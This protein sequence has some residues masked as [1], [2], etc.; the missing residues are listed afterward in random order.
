MTSR[1][2]V[3]VPVYRAADKTA[4]CLQSIDLFTPPDVPLLL[5]DDG[6][7]DDA[8]DALL[9]A[10]TIESARPVQVVQRRD[11][12]GFV[13]TS[14]QIFELSGQSDVLLVNSDVI[15]SPG[16]AECLQRIADRYSSCATVTA[17]TN[18]GTLAALPDFQKVVDWRD[19]LA[20][21]YP[22]SAEQ[23]ATLPTAIGHCVYIRRTALDLLGPFDLAFG[24]GYGEEVDFSQRALR[25]GFHHLLACDVFVYHF[26]SESF[27]LKNDVEASRLQ[28]D[29]EVSRRYPTYPRQVREAERMHSSSG[30]ELPRITGLRSWLVH[31]RGLKLGIDY[32]MVGVEGT[33]TAQ[34][35]TETARALAQQEQVQELTLYVDRD[36]PLLIEKPSALL[37]G[38]DVVVRRLAVGEVPIQHE[39][40]AFIRPSQFNHEDELALAFAAAPR[41][42]LHVLD[43]IAYENPC[44]WPDEETWIQYR[45]LQERSVASADSVSALSE[46]VADW[47]VAAGLTAERPVIAHCGI[48]RRLLLGEPVARADNGRVLRLVQYGAAFLHKNREFTVSVAEELA[49]RGWAVELDLAGPDPTWG[50]SREGELARLS[51]A[52]A[53][54]H[55]AA[56]K[57]GEGSLVWTRSSFVSDATLH[58]LVRSATVV[59]Y[60][61]TVEGFGLVPF[62][63]GAWGVPC[64]SSGGGSLREVLPSVAVL[65]SFSVKKWADAVECL[66]REPESRAANVAALRSRREHLEWSSSAAL[67]AATSLSALADPRAAYARMRSQQSPLL[68]Q[69]GG[70]PSQV[71]LD[72]LR[73][74]EAE[75]LQIY[76][77]RR[78]SAM[79]RIMLWAGR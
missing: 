73:Q 43:G 4:L 64:L 6:S 9:A 35:V 15:V 16:W 34:L 7:C 21:R 10:V 66:A 77:S 39:C 11:N 51:V 33:G 30:L 69:V 70:G 29:A 23:V 1:Y 74:C 78:W 3:A 68:L 40:D 46:S 41:W 56:N 22:S 57:G 13:R 20:G 25:A 26:G 54:V 5:V 8:V 27:A 76:R 50:S 37:L 49:L 75:L 53:A 2:V 36:N 45:Q 79:S 14:N 72:R 28:G 59:L 63:V 71:E 65:S 58:D 17:A 55:A 62:E 47:M 18:H 60:P 12:Q 32:R 61:S 24:E 42:H 48:P 52:E 31:A 44:Y 67:F 38:D 19:V